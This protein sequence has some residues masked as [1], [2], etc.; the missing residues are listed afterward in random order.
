MFPKLENSAVL[1]LMF[2]NQNCQNADVYEDESAIKTMAVRPNNKAHSGS[3]S[4]LQ[5][6]TSSMCTHQ[7]TRYSE[8]FIK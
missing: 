4:V 7:P 2:I 3:M 8:Q 6:P 5:D 1:S